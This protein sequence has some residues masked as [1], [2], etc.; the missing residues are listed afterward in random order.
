[1]EDG[2]PLA[3]ERADVE[4]IRDPRREA[5]DLLDDRFVRN[6]DGDRPAHREPE[7]DDARRADLRHGRARVVDA[8]LEA[9]PR[10]HPVAHLCEAELR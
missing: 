1:M 10:L 2:E 3:S 9:P 8:R 5:Y 4:L 7:Q 6:R